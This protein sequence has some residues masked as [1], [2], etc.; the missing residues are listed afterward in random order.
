VIAVDTNVLVHAH[1]SDSPWHGPALAAVASLA[2]RRWCIPWPCAHEFLAIAT[3]PRIFDPPTPL[4]TA[5]QTLDDWAASPTMVFV[6][7]TEEHLP[8][9]AET[10]RAGKIVGP[11]IHD[12]RIAAICIAHAV[13]ELWTADR[14]FSRIAGL[15]VRN[16]LVG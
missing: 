15:V 14:D 5:L 9:L 4:D 7:E 11:M 6:G 3:H 12:A 8:T 16:P 1:R 10:L 13:H 2:G